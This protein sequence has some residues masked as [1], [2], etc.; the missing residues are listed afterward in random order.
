MVRRILPYLVLLAVFA[1]IGNFTW[2]VAEAKSVGDA[3]NGYESGGRYFVYRQP[4]YTEVSRATWEWLRF[5]GISMIAT[6]LLAMAAAAYL[7]FQFDFPGLMKGKITPD[8]MAER[9]RAIEASGPLLAS[10][11][12][13]GRIGGL[14]FSGS[15]LKASVYPGGIVV[16]PV[17]MATRTIL[18]PEI[19]SVTPARM[20]VSQTL[21]IRHAGVDSRSPLILSVAGDSAIAAA[22]RSM[23]GPGGMPAAYPTSRFEYARQVFGPMLDYSSRLA[24]Y[25]RGLAVL[26]VLGSGF[27]VL[28]PIV[29]FWSGDPLIV[30][31]AGL[32]LVILARSLVSLVR[33][34]RDPG[35]N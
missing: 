16:K 26:L 21:E 32:T 7:L 29:A 12:S 15:L 25:P 9:A 3:L 8:A 19:S 34:P 28:G 20:F 31:F 17:F 11:K 24:S 6:H 18:A 22:I 33:Q 35:S 27:L 23:A 30:V 10:A 13:G 14:G 5:H 4:G 1:G 2:F